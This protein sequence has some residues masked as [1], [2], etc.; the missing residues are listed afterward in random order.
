MR[1][2]TAAVAGTMAGTALLVG[3]KLG[4]GNAATQETT[5]AADG[6]VPA[7]QGDGVDPGAA[8]APEATSSVRPAP[9]R[10]SARPRGSTTTRPR[11][12][13]AATRSSAPSSGG[14][15]SGLRDGAFS[16]APST[17]QYGTVRVSITVSDGRITNVKAT[18]ATAPAKTAQINSGAVPKL[19]QE[20]L[21]AQSA[22]IA[23]V[24]G[25]TYTSSSYRAS[26]QSAINAAKA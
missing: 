2:T 14:S 13:G 25:A 16:G 8:P 11:A 24:S 23:T 5:V 10:S 21:A 12:T 18:Y 6:S 26:L 19:R 4:A 1:R 17:N 9:R 7:A 15:A 3:L 22:R 20:A